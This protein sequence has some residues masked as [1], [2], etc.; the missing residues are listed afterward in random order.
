MAESKYTESSIKSLS[1]REHI[2]HRPGMYIGKLGDGSSPDDGIYVLIKE[3]V[4]NAIDE[5]T[6]GHGKRIDIS[7]Q[8]GIVSVRDFGRGIPLAKVRACAGEIT[9]GGKYDSRAFQKSVG[10]NGVGHRR[11]ARRPAP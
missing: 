3:I 1:P 10:L 4:D 9:P 2:R 5:H 8:D 11:P 6:S 7:I